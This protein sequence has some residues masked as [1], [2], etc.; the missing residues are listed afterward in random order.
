M[1]KMGIHGLITLAVE[2]FLDDLPVQAGVVRPGHSQHPLESQISQAGPIRF[3]GD[4][5]LAA[6]GGA[7]CWH[8]RSHQPI[9]TREKKSWRLDQINRLAPSSCFSWRSDQTCSASS[10]KLAYLPVRDSSQSPSPSYPSYR[11]PPTIF[12]LPPT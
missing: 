2:D 3:G 6:I 11:H 9:W 1:S 5:P 7:R 10:L 8:S 4:R 12:F